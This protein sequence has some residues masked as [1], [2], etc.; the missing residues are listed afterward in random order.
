M[1]RSKTT[2][3]SDNRIHQRAE[4][5]ANKL[6]EAREDKNLREQVKLRAILISQKV[7][8]YPTYIGAAKSLY[9]FNKINQH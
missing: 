5:Y 1:L 2:Q 7:I 9:S 4:E 3:M 6:L 8:D